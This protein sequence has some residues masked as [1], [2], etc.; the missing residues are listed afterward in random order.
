MKE[1]LLVDDDEHSVELFELILKKENVKVTR[2][3]DGQEAKKIL[4]RRDAF[5]LL[6]VDVFMPKMGGLDF[7]DY[8]DGRFP[9][10]LISGR[11]RDEMMWENQPSYDAFL[12]KDQ[13][14]QH[15]MSAMA[16]AMERWEMFHST[17]IAA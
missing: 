17:P 15:L 7:C 2:A 6:I 14:R 9:V 13:V 4:E 3:S 1:V 5:D 16:K 12:E 11:K 10:L 8:V